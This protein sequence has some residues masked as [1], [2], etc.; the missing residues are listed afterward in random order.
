MSLYV[1]N[2]CLQLLK[3]MALFQYLACVL[4]L[5]YSSASEFIQNG[6]DFTHNVDLKHDVTGEKLQVKSFGRLANIITLDHTD[7]VK[8]VLCKGPKIL[9]IVNHSSLAS[10]WSPGDIVMGSSK[11]GC[12]LSPPPNS[13]AG[14]HRKIDEIKIRSEKKVELST[15]IANFADMFEH[16]KVFYRHEPGKLTNGTHHR[17]KRKDWWNAFP[18]PVQYAKEVLT[19][20]L[21]PIHWS[22]HKG[23]VGSNFNYDPSSGIAGGKFDAKVS[24]QKDLSFESESTLL[25]HD[26]SQESPGKNREI[27]NVAMELD[28]MSCYAYFDS[29]FTF[30]LEIDVDPETRRGRFKHYL[31][32][33]DAEAKVQ[34]ELEFKVT[35]E[36]SAE[37]EMLL[38]KG[39]TIPLISFPL[40]P[41]PFGATVSLEVSVNAALWFEAKFQAN[42]EFSMALGFTSL[43]KY[44]LTHSKEKGLTST[45]VLR[46]FS[47][48]P[49]T[50]NHNANVEGEVSI[51]PKFEIDVSI[52]WGFGD[53]FNIAFTAPLEISLKPEVKITFGFEKE[54]GAL[55]TG[56]LLVE[57]GLALAV[58][59]KE[60]VSVSVVAMGTTWWKRVF[61][62]DTINGPI[63]LTEDFTL[64][65]KRSMVCMAQKNGSRRKRDV[66]RINLCP[67]STEYQ[68][69]DKINSHM[70]SKFA[71]LRELVESVTEK[72]LEV[73][74]N[75]DGGYTAVIRLRAATETDMRLLEEWTSCGHVFCN[76]KR[77]LDNTLAIRISRDT[78]KNTHDEYSDNAGDPTLSQVAENA[79]RV[80]ILPVGQGDATVIQCPRS[81]HITFI[82]MGSISSKSSGYWKAAKVSRFLGSG[83]KKLRRVYITHADEDHVN[84]L[85]PVL[86]AHGLW[87]EINPNV[88]LIIPQHA[89]SRVSTFFEE[90]N[91]RRIGRCLLNECNKETYDP[92]IC[93]D[94]AQIHIL[95]SGQGPSKN[96]GGLV[97]RLTY[98]GQSMLFPG[99][100]GSEA[101]L[102]NSGQIASTVYKLA[103]YGASTSGSNI[104]SFLGA[105]NPSVVVSNGDPQYNPAIRHPRCDVLQKVKSRLQ[106]KHSNIEFSSQRT[107]SC[108]GSKYGEYENEIPTDDLPVFTSTPTNTSLNLIQID[109]K[110]GNVRVTST[111][112]DIVTPQE[113]GIGHGTASGTK[114]RSPPQYLLRMEC[115]ATEPPKGSGDVS[116]EEVCLP[117]EAKITRDSDRFESLV[118]YTYGDVMF[119]DNERFSNWCGN[120]GR[121]CSDCLDEAFNDNW[122]SCADRMMAPKMVFLIRRLAALVYQTWPDDDDD[123]TGTIKIRNVMEYS[124]KNR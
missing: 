89:N 6:R 123:K 93:S 72:D 108:G 88:T 18:E 39:K 120:P 113:K 40:I 51:Y 7:G 37:L 47:R 66:K 95:S 122:A 114:K 19:E 8:R 68:T 14:I 79:L 90:R 77:L 27:N 78:V 28:C 105:V 16:A 29:A 81:G 35:D 32:Q 109:F 55:A 12:Y 52:S 57:G 97:L 20:K 112:R 13:V 103:Q 33:F 75:A 53:L 110:N 5:L 115:D 2:F 64:V 111:I 59:E 41:L 80:Y 49:S 91:V 1:F 25:D 86:N 74:G 58:A 118:Q 62:H 54:L 9:V 34:Y 94:S 56:R 71:M 36:F 23:G 3:N 4:C 31:L 50:V 102:L 17:Q 38:W 24:R 61:Y 101:H 44:T 119:E 48:L 46:P 43:A 117:M 98:K 42:T 10:S 60:P 121:R 21:T 96:N 106:E 92:N 70:Q 11:W 69:G 67:I 26:R 99:D 107:Y 83:I 87:S 63:R 82:D 100:M 45:S 22:V 15:S 104:D 85:Q 30:E 73:I 124:F 76:S 65:N 116:L 84:M